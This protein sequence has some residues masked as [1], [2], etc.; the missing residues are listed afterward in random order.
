MTQR[1]IRAVYELKGTVQAVGFRPTLHRLATGCGLGGSVQNRSGV[2]RLCLEGP[3]SDVDSFVRDLPSHLPAP[4]LI[5]SCAE[6]E[7]CDLPAGGAASFVILPSE[8]SGGTGVLIPPDLAV[9][10]ACAAEVFDRADRRYGY[11]FTTCTLCGPRYTVLNAMPYDRARTTLSAFPVCPDCRREYD[12]PANRRFHAETIACSACGPRLWLEDSAGQT[13]PG[14]PLRA[15]RKALA[16]GAIVAVRG[17]G[18]FLLAADATNRA[19]LQRLRE[20]K[21]RPHKPFAVMAPDLA[22]AR[23][24]CTVSDPIAAMLQSP[25][26]PIA[27]LDVPDGA[28]GLLPL[29]VLTPDTQTLGVML[30]TSP[31]HLLLARP[32][33]GDPV[34]AFDLLVMTSGNRRGEPICL[35]NAEAR[36][37][38][39]GIANYYL[40][41]DR[42]I[43]L[44][45]DDS[46]CAPARDG[47]QVWRRSRGF[48]PDA[49]AL[50]RRLPRSVLAMGAGLKNAVAFGYEDR[51]VL[52]PHIGDLDTP[53]SVEGLRKVAEALPRFLGRRPE[54][55]AV[56]MHPDLQSSL[57]GREIATAKGIP[58]IE[59]QH[60]HAHALACLAENGRE[61]G[62]ALVFDGTGY[63][64]DGTI[65]GA[66]LLDVNG[67]TFRRLAA[68][69]PV[70]LPG[71]DEAIRRPARQLIG[72]LRQAGVEPS[73]G[74]LAQLGVTADELTAWSLQCDHRVNCPLTRG[75]G[76]LFDCMAARIGIA[77]AF[78]TYDGQA[79]IRLEAA[80]RRGSGTGVAEL[81][82][83]SRT[84][85]GMLEIDWALAFQEAPQ[86]SVEELALAFHNA[87]ARAATE[88]V[89]FG[90]QATGGSS[91]ALSGGVFMNRVLTDLLTRRLEEAGIA[92]LTH[93]RTSPNDGAIA[94]GQVV[95]AAER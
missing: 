55:V 74:Q 45:N 88:M 50:P 44:R 90:L 85:D 84:V 94:L 76:R 8:A 27:I 77:P 11:A 16:D 9:C 33:S 43:N 87:V 83:A 23:R 89:A 71:G 95:A 46:V 75:A 21:R 13:Q 48:A 61:S 80:A 67:G 7:R 18:G 36:A 51:A 65:W 64:T 54:S 81:P 70:P 82:Y 69:A 3:A 72:R 49:V 10:P 12:D 29:D 73:P 32:L 91:I 26:A 19:A 14:D 1:H 17:I 5:E 92:V 38:L 58:V 6:L 39:A 59:V 63:G 57:V 2:V 47:W 53:E 42:E 93:H 30:P 15:A 60:H 31:L 4:A 22:T 79:A 25:Q 78:V 56:D 20:R 28:R 41:H 35:T 40:L 62:L 37:R 66:E 68:F 34:S 52:S 86:G 24:Y